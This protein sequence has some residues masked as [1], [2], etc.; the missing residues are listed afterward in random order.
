MKFLPLMWANLTDK[1]LRTAFTFLSIVFAFLLY[2]VLGAVKNAFAGGA[3]FAG[4]DRLRMIHKVSIVQALPVHYYDRIITTEGV[5]GATYVL[6]FGGEY[7]DPR[8][9]FPQL[10][11]N[12]TFLDVYLEYEL[13]A[14]ERKQWLA[15]RTGAIVGKALAERFDWQVGDR[16]GLKSKIYN[17]VD[18]KDTW[19]FTLEGIFD[20][21]SDSADEAQ[22][23]FHYEY[24]EESSPSA[25]GEV[26]W[27]VVAVADDAEPA[28]VAARLDA[29]F[30]NSSTATKTSTERAF[31]QAFVNQVGDTATIITSVVG[32]TFFVIL[33]V[34]GNAVAH[35][36]HERRSQLAV[37]KAVGFSDV[38]VMCFVIGECALLCSFAGVLGMLLAGW[39]TQLGVSTLG[40]TGVLRLST[41]DIV[42]GLL[43]IALLAAASSI[44]PAA[45]A[46]R[47]QVA[48][49]LGRH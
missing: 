30:A 1:K 33:L 9:F 16:I 20:G 44:V 18:G 36:V 19:E 27:F 6:W 24:L 40:M 22:M 25:R 48:T 31:L 32:V 46:L 4:A 37:L 42:D 49:G 41:A 2:G 38:R 5:A 43:W 13:D 10:A 23:F 35:S 39:V 15:T 34:V 8:N 7:Q 28:V 47:L 45:S 11:V 12:P 14:K 17:Q 26:R 29:Q 21:A 3:E